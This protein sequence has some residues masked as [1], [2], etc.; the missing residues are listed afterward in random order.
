L[1]AACPDA[2]FRD[3]QQALEHA[4]IVQI[5][6]TAPIDLKLA[7]LAAAK[8]ESGALDDA[9]GHQTE[10]VRLAPLERKEMS[11]ERLK[12]YQRGEAYRRKPGWWRQK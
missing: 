10:A 3:G 8:A 5:L 1:R 4:R 9:V 12:L 6:P 7:L 11:G 2:N